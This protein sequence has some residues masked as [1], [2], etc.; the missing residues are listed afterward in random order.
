V[1]RVR[2]GGVPASTPSALALVALVDVL[3][4]RSTAFSKLGEE[5]ADVL[6][7]RYQD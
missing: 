1:V 3:A 7:V 4:V 2:R 6:G 5:L